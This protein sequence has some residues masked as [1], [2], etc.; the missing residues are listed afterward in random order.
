MGLSAGV[1]CAIG[2]LLVVAVDWGSGIDTRLVGRLVEYRSRAL[3]QAARHVTNAGLLSVLLVASAAFAVGVS[4]RLGWRADGA[5]ALSLVIGSVVSQTLKQW[6]E[7]PR[8]PLALRATATSGWAFPSG[9]ATN[10]AAFFVAT[11][12]VLLVLVVRER[13]WRI[14]V[15]SGATLLVLLVGASRV[16]LAAHWPRDVLAGWA[17]GLLVACACAAIS[18]WSPARTVEVGG[19][20]DELV[21]PVAE[22]LN[23]KV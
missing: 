14:A 3:L 11:A 8:P 12:M 9:H 22:R 10:A 1:V 19:T 20:L 16:V 15:I 4:R 2:T 17:V 21:T 7:R 23:Q 5:P 6:F 13:A 18:L